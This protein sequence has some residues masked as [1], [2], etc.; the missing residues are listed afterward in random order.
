MPLSKKYYEKIAGALCESYHDMTFK[1]EDCR[2]VLDDLAD[3]LMKQFKAD[4]PRFD[5]A[6]FLKA[7]NSKTC[8]I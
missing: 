1:S 7:V 2:I 4:N 8:K 3:E 6:R 5:R